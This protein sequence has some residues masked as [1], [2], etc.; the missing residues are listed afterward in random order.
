MPPSR[1]LKSCLALTSLSLL[2]V[3]VMIPDAAAQIIPD[4]TLGEERSQVTPFDALGLPVDVIEGGAQRDINLFHSFLEFNVSEGR[5]AFFFSPVGIEHI[6][7]RV[8]GTNPSEIF[9]QLGV[10]ADA[11]L[12]PDLFLINPNGVLFGENASLSL[13]GSFAAVTANGIEF[14]TAGVFSATTPEVPSPLL[15][16]DP[17]A[18]LFTQLPTGNII[19]QSVAPFSADADVPAGLQVGGRESLLLLGGDVTLDGG[20]L[21]TLGGQVEIGAIADRGRVALNPD[22]LVIPDHMTRG[23]VT[24]TNGAGITVPTVTGGRIQISA[25][26]ISLNGGSFLLLG[27]SPGF[28]DPNSQGGNIRLDA[29]GTIQLTGASTI[30]NAVFPGAVG[31]GGDIELVAAVLEVVDGAQVQARTDG[32]GAA[33]NVGIMAGDRVTIA[34]ANS[35]LFSNVGVDGVGNGGNVVIS[36][37]VL[38]VLNGGQIQADTAGTGNAG[39]V[40]ITAADQVTIDG[41]NSAIFS[42]VLATG[43]G[44]GGSVELTAPV[45]RVLNGGQ[46]QTSTEGRGNAGTVVISASDRV[47]F[48]GTSPDGAFNSSAFSQVD[49]DAVGNGGDIIITTGALEVSDGA[50]LVTNTAGDGNAGHV[51]LTVEHQASFDGGD[52]LTA[53]EPNGVGEGGDITITAASLEVLNGGSLSANTNGTGDAGNIRLT[54]SDRFTLAGRM[55]ANSSSVFSGVNA[56]GTGQGGNVEVT[57]V[58]VDIRDNAQLAAS[59]FGLGNAGNISLVGRDRATIDNG[60]I[61]SEVAPTATGEGGTITMIGGDLQVRNGGQLQANTEGNGNAGNIILSGATIGLLE[62]G[63]LQASSRGN[64]DAGSVTLEASDRVTLTNTLS[65]GRVTSASRS[66]V[67]SRLGVGGMGNGGD[68]TITAETLEVLNGSQLVANTAGT[69]DAGTITIVASDTVTLDSGL[70]L[71]R[72]LSGAFSRVDAGGDGDGGDINISTGTLDVLNGAQLQANTFG[73]GDAGRISITAGDRVRFSGRSANGRS[74]SAAFS[75]VNV[76]AIGDGNDIEINTRILAVSNGAGLTT[77]TLGQGNAGDILINANDH[78]VLDGVFVDSDGAVNRQQRSAIGSTVEATGNGAGGNISINT[79][80][81]AVRE[82]ALVSSSTLG[83]GDAGK[84][85]I[86][87]SDRVILDGTVPNGRVGSAVASAVAGE[88]IGAGNNIILVTDRLRVV[89]GAE[90][91]ATTAAAGDAG[92]IRVVANDA[93]TVDN[94]GRISVAVLD[95]A[96]GN[97]QSIR[98]QTPQLFVTSGSEISAATAGDGNAGDIRLQITDAIALSDSAITSEVAETGN[99]DGGDITIQTGDL[100]LG[101]RARISA[102]SFNQPEDDE[103][104]STEVRSRA[105]IRQNTNSD[106]VTGDAGNIIIAVDNGLFMD[107]SSI[108]TEAIAFAGGNID[109]SATAMRLEGNGDIQTNVRSG[110]EGGGN[111]ILSA[112]SILAFEDSDI[113]AFADEGQGGDITLDTIAFFGENFTTASLNQN[114]D[115]LDGND[116][117]DINATG[118]FSGTVTLPDLSFIRNSLN[119]LPDTLVDPDTLIANSCVVRSE[120]GRSTFIITGAGGLPQQPGDS[121]VANYPTGDIQSIPDDSSSTAPQWHIGHPI[122]EPE[123][124]YQ[125]PNGELILTHP[126]P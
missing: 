76:G 97:A 112:D 43:V 119:T 57:A 49:R 38:E 67:F 96:V 10:V 24:L 6:F 15:T 83:N 41:L 122:I 74:A 36:A 123:G 60:T 7:S 27:I 50:Q 75:S 18:F 101:D 116:R 90:I 33:G 22:G 8:T 44:N 1:S 52:I 118:A 65:N 93:I 35:A 117:V 69:G 32:T 82:G 30:Q 64:G 124:V 21:T 13:E 16:V 56:T 23:N 26:D 107:D 102:R 85:T 58:V 110:P 77:S 9:G 108:T 55:G 42:E 11:G 25:Q 125:L 37:P 29:S 80:R 17:S 91:V 115:E 113:L 87:A 63:Q 45:V 92:R 19:N 28:D 3:L 126:C 70:L 100:S 66:G 40:V 34:D 20:L 73:E 39:R 120:A 98:L 111:I 89:N 78:V 31:N 104:I 5:S 106:N 105:N 86:D 99:G 46:V 62:G 88:A 47:V 2:G 68:I 81:L 4:D 72:V 94:Q 103:T 48:S 53:V 71:G 54:V 12:A 79:T 51:I 59:T 84:I 114:P 14:G 95:G 121:G 61:F 109:I